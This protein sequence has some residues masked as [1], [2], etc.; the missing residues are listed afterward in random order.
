MLEFEHAHAHIILAIIFLC[1]FSSTL[2][3]PLSLN[4]QLFF[5]IWFLQMLRKPCFNAQTQNKGL[6]YLYFLLPR[7]FLIDFWCHFLIPVWSIAK[8]YV[9]SS[10][11][12]IYKR[13]WIIY[14]CD[15]WK[16]HISHSVRCL[17]SLSFHWMDVLTQFKWDPFG[18][19]S[20]SFSFTFLFSLFVKS[21]EDN[22]T[23]PLVY[24]IYGK[25]EQ[26][27]IDVIVY[28]EFQSMCAFVQIKMNTTTT[29]TIAA[30]EW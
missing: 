27:G 21:F 20:F 15:Q 16:A 17:L 26:V 28:I 9:P 4:A 24:C 6:C 5:A 1:H 14:C 30:H 7:C 3:F 22:N 8:F 11:C 19:G 25:T 18:Y 12:S 10:M 2:I 29:T 13:I 23:S